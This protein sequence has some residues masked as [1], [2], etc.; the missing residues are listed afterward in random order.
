MVRRH[1]GVGEPALPSDA[2]GRLR[3]NGSI[4]GAARLGC[5]WTSGRTAA[6]VRDAQRP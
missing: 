6:G 1:A 5:W 2:E 3:A 4:P